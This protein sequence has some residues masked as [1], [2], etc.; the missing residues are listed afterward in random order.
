MMMF[1]CQFR[2]NLYSAAIPEIDY[3]NVL[4]KTS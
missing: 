2:A 4:N 3:S 1:Y